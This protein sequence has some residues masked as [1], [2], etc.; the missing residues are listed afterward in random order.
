MVLGEFELRIVLTED[1]PNEVKSVF[2]E[3]LEYRKRGEFE[4]NLTDEKDDLYFHI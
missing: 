2:N 4:F 3:L 1:N